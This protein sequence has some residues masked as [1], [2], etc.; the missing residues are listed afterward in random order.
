MNRFLG[1]AVAATCFSLAARSAE[2]P[3]VYKPPRSMDG[4]AELEG[5]WKNSNLTP[6]E[7]SD[8]IGH[9]TLT[10]AEAAALTRDYFDSGKD[11]PDD[12]GRFLEHRSFE[13]IRGTFRS[14]VIID[15][16]DGKLPWSENHKN[17]QSALRRATMNAFDNPEDR[18]P[19]ERCL[20]STASPPLVPTLDNNLFHIVQTPAV[21]AIA[22][23]LIH[24]VRIVRMNSTHS[25]DGTGSWLGDSIGWWEKDTL[26]VEATNFAPHSGVRNR[27]RDTFL[28][29]PHTVVTERFTR[30]SENEINYMFTVTDPNLYARP[31]T[32]E[33]H[34]LKSSERMFEYA[35]HEGDY[36]MRNILQAA[37]DGE[38]QAVKP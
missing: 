13:A 21:I 5:T 26:V 15:P 18:P 7:R 25:P 35:C 20:A 1:V 12:P 4:H 33:T 23:E 37:R 17:D 6:L 11:M 28:V 14:S 27:G 38:A 32:G 19:P 34:L 30:V 22:S 36:S 8:K 3:T 16:A 10:A 29:S 24:D 9:A 2:A 31:W